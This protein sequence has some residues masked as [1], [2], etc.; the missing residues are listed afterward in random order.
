MQNV[1]L[2]LEFIVQY[3]N[4]HISSKRKV[5]GPPGDPEEGA[6]GPLMIEQAVTHRKVVK[7]TV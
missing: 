7:T 1:V 5:H 3:V 2:C 6:E 4:M